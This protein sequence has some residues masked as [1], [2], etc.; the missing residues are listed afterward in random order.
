MI[1]RRGRGKEVSFQF[2]SHGIFRIRVDCRGADSVTFASNQREF[3]Q[4]AADLLN[5]QL[6]SSEGHKRTHIGG[7]AQAP[8][9]L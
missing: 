9:V 7:V 3:C 4:H 8:D 5:S 6:G 1:A 2:R